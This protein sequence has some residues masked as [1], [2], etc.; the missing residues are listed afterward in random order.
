MSGLGHSRLNL[1]APIMSGLPPVA[2]VARTSQIGGFVPIG[3]HPAAQQRGGGLAFL[4][5]QGQNPGRQ[6][7]ASRFRR[8]LRYGKE[9]L[10]F[11]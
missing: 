1:A 5:G 8:F 6:S 2:T 3:E 4:F 11:F 7:L 9:R 10:L